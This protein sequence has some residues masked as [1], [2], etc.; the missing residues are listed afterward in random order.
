MSMNKLDHKYNNTLKG[1]FL[2]NEIMNK[3]LNLTK[4]IEVNISEYENGHKWFDSHANDAFQCAHPGCEAQLLLCSFRIDNL[5]PPY[6]R[7]EPPTK[8]IEGCLNAY[9]THSYDPSDLCNTRYVGKSAFNA[10]KK[11]YSEGSERNLS[12][13][14]PASR[15]LTPFPK[16]N[17]NHDG[18]TKHKVKV[19]PVIY[20]PN[21]PIRA[22]TTYLVHASDFRL[23]TDPNRLFIN[24]HKF[25]LGLTKETFEFIKNSEEDWVVY[26]I[27]KFIG[28]KGTWSY[29]SKPNILIVSKGKIIYEQNWRDFEEEARNEFLN[30]ERL[31]NDR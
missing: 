22:E 16:K 27:S 4:N 26:F 18:K 7:T 28:T 5:V 10:I 29:S 15:T 21:E 25:G 30:N 14:N 24:L 17:G 12:I 20:D 9:T 6:F 2:Y 23:T 11:R 3:A 19:G 13:Y 31:W 1:I 8:H